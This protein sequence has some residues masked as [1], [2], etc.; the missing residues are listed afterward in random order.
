[1]CGLCGAFGSGHWAEEGG[2]RARARRVELLRR[3]LR[4]AGLTLDE[5]KQVENKVGKGVVV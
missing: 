4:T 3:V 2:R 1:M 5:W